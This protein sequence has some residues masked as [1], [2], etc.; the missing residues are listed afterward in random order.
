MTLVY[1]HCAKIYKFKKNTFLMNIVGVFLWLNAYAFVVASHMR[2]LKDHG[3]VRGLVMSNII[4]G[5]AV[6]LVVVLAYQIGM[7]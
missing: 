3:F 2:M 5:A 6:L 7:T 4:I 1:K